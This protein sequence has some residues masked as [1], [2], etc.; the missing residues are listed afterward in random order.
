MELNSLSITSVVFTVVL[1]SK[2]IND[3]EGKKMW[4]NY[5][6]L[7]LKVQNLAKV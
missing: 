7:K 1:G 4:K 2:V 5:K 3:S 6:D